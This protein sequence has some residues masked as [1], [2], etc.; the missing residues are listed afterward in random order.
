MPRIH[1]NIGSN[2]GD[3]AVLIEC[4]VAAICR[5]IDAD[6]RAEIRLAPIQESEAWG[7]ES[8]SHFL[9]LGMMVDIPGDVDPVGLLTM[10]QEAER[11]VSDTP[12]RSSDG[13][14]ID[15]KIDID[16][17]AIDDMILDSPSLTLPHPRM[18]LRDFVLQP[19]ME[20]D[21]DWCHPLT[22][23]TASEMLATLKKARRLHQGSVEG[24]V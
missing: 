23:K 24:S 5:R 7:F 1:I 18:H 20:L 19:V 9:N 14:Y 16:L 4:A 10:L 11:E 13:N 3:R 8:D 6:C 17:I 2:I 22:G 15:R 21:P 12:H